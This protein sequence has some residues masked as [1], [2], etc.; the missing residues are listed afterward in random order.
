MKQYNCL[1]SQRECCSWRHV[2]LVSISNTQL[3]FSEFGTSGVARSLVLAGHLLYASHSHMLCARSC[4]MS[5]MKHGAFGWACARPGPA[6]ATPLFGTKNGYLKDTDTTLLPYWVFLPN[7]KCVI[8]SSSALQPRF[9]VS[10]EGT[11][12]VQSLSGVNS[13]P[14]HNLS[15]TIKVDSEFQV[16]SIHRH[17][18]HCVSCCNSI[19][20]EFSCSQL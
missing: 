14:D 13:N 7:F 20:V 9:K 5:G 19:E 11:V 15:C 6:F 16:Y 10:C 18:R 12:I 4:N 1:Y 2:S 17:T 8:L 3:L